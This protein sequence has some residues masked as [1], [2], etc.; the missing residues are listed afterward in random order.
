[1]RTFRV[2]AR[3]GEEG[4]DLH[5]EG[6]GTAVAERLTRAEAVAREYVA[7]ALGLAGDSFAVEVAVVLDPETERMI[8]RAREASRSAAQA[9]REA[10]R[11]TRAVVDRLRRQ[12]LNGREIARCLGVSPQRVSQLMG[13]GSERGP[14]RAG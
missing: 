12:G 11:Q 13:G 9:Q 14:A 1:M 3:R 4:W 2:R 8:H 5:V 10:A 6:V 7:A